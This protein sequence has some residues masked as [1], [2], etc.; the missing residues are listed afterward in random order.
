MKFKIYGTNLRIAP[1]TYSNLRCRTPDVITYFYPL[2]VILVNS[3]SSAWILAF[4]LAIPKKMYWYSASCIFR[5]KMPIWYLIQDKSIVWDFQEK[6]RSEV[7]QTKFYYN[8]EVKDT[9]Y[10]GDLR[11]F[12][13]FIVATDANLS[14][15]RTFKKSPKKKGWRLISTP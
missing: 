8:L 5:H 3:S 11:F 14:V 4:S 7:T 9:V 6:S 12:S 1:A 13:L 2:I 10:Y 15:H